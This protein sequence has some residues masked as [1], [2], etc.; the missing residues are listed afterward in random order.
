MEKDFKINAYFSNDGEELEELLSNYL[1]SLLDN[2]VVCA[3]KIN[4]IEF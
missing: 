1:S 4:L 3:K 2:K